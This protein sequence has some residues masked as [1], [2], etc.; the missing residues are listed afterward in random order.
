MGDDPKPLTMAELMAEVQRRLD[1]GP[2][3][4]TAVPRRVQERRASAEAQARIAA[5]EAKPHPRRPRC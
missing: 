1:R 4:S 5:G 2:N 3:P